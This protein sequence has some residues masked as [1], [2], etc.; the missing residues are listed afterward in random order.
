MFKENMIKNIEKIKFN[1][2]KLFKHPITNEVITRD[3]YINLVLDDFLIEQKKKINQLDGLSILCSLE[4]EINHNLGRIIL[5]C[6]NLNSLNLS[7]LLSQALL[8][9]IYWKYRHPNCDV[10]DNVNMTVIKKIL[11]FKSQPKLEKIVTPIT[12]NTTCFICGGKATIHI[13]SY[14]D[15]RIIF[16]CNDCWHTYQTGSDGSYSN[17]HLKNQ[18]IKC[19]CKFCNSIKNEIYNRGIEWINNLEKT[20]T[21]SIESMD[22][23][24]GIPNDN[25]MEKAYNIYID[26]QNDNQIN[27]ILN[28][29]PSSLNE[30]LDITRAISSLHDRDYYELLISKLKKFNIIFNVKKKTNIDIKIIIMRYLLEHQYKNYATEENFNKFK[31]YILSGNFITHYEMDK[32]L[33][34]ESYYAIMDYDFKPG[35]SYYYN[36][37][38]D[39]DIKNLR[40]YLYEDSLFV[41]P[42]FINK[43]NYNSKEYLINEINNLIIDCSES[44]LKLILE[45]T[46]AIK[47]VNNS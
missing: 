40:E 17:D 47:N 3:D 46:K 26:K 19:K 27:E 12:Y 34:N 20:F 16:K 35:L 31:T 29:N 18:Y 24:L 28:N 9:Y 22:E 32:C 11:G 23:Y 41:N 38:N 45:T 36:I 42:Y 5:K 8:T 4:S 1:P 2:N 30:L 21:N 43:N 14:I 44:T 6:S 33:V 10:R 37:L 15:N 13:P 7:K 25:F 39:I